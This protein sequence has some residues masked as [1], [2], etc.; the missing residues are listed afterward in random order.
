M[1]PRSCTHL[2]YTNTHMVAIASGCNWIGY[3]CSWCSE[4]LEPLKCDHE[5]S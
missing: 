2:L 4:I 5:D 1:I 3:I